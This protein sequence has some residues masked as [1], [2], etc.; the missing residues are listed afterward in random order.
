MTVAMREVEFKEPVMVG[1]V[2][3][4][5]AQVARVGKT[6][7]TANVRV[8]AHAPR[9][10]RSARDVTQAEVVYVNVGGDGRPE[11]VAQD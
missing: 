6:S 7:I 3:T 8:V 9:T 2:L 4:C 1:D 5:Y 11:P 10:Q